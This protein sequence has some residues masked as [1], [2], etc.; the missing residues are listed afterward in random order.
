MSSK[1]HNSK[2]NYTNTKKKDSKRQLETTTRIRIDLERLED[3]ESLDTSFLEGRLKKDF[4]SNKSKREKFILKEMSSKIVVFTIFVLL[5]FVAVICFF[6][7]LKFEGSQKV[8]DKKAKKEVN[9]TVIKKEIDDNYLFV[10]DFY[11]ENFN[12]EDVSFPYVKKSNK[13]YDTKDILDDMKHIIYQY[14]PSVVFLEIGMNDLNND[15]SEE[16]IVNRISRIIDEIKENRPFAD[17][18]VESIYPI[19]MD[20]ENYDEDILDDSVTLK[21]ISSL[22]KEIKNLTIEKKIHYLDVYKE[23]VQDGQLNEKYT[24]NGIYLNELGYDRVLKLIKK[25]IEG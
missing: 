9:N 3:S 19:N 25:V 15:D 22:N 18:Y 24:D 17:I 2:N 7:Y 1:A 14:N 4:Y 12:L 8:E 6:P 23:L 20:V 11:T 21:K 10:G 5:V 16:D 13:D